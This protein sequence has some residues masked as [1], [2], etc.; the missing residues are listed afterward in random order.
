MTN[1]WRDFKNSDVF[2]VIGAN[3]A[4]NHPCGWKWAFVARDEHGAKI[5]HVDPRFT[6]TSATADTYV[7]IRAGTD[8][9]FF[10]GLVNYIL[11]NKLY[12]EDYVRLHTN[13]G[14][15]VADEFEFADGLFSGYDQAA[16]TYDT[17]SW[18]YSHE[19]G[20]LNPSE[21]VTPGA[22][23]TTPADATQPVFARVDPTLQDPRCVFQLM[24]QHYARYTAEM[25]ERVC[26]IPQDKFR[27]VA[28][29]FG[30]TGTADKVGSIEITAITDGARTNPIPDKYVVNVSKDAVNGSMAT[31]RAIRQGAFSHQTCP[32]VN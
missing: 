9:A 27:D 16:R 17:S 30:A 32:P 20:D 23:G 10:G 2:L 19:T 28:Q 7:P 26:G 11:E 18:T 13:A 31:A 5:I 3:P 21:E 1:H 29:T 4:E 14:F 8:T 25:V 24:K 15:V 6:R 12:H 22:E